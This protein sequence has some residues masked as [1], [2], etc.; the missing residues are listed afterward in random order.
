[1]K[2]Y[3]KIILGDDDGDESY[4]KSTSGK[5]LSIGGQQSFK[6]VIEFLEELNGGLPLQDSVK[7]FNKKAKILT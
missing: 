3:Y 1:M 4:I 2:Q 7:K 6:N 5:I